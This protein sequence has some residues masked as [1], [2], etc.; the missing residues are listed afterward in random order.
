MIATHAV[1]MTTAADLAKRQRWVEKFF[2]SAATLPLSFVF[3]ETK[4]TG[5]PDAWQPVT[6]RRRIDAN[7]IETSF[8]GTD[9]VTGLQVRVDCWTYQ[10]YPV[11]EWVVWLTNN[12]QTATPIIRDLLALDGA[13]P[14]ATPVLTHCNGDFYS[15]AGYTAAET[16][17]PAGER[18]TFAPKGGRSCD[19]AF[20][21]YRLTFADGGLAL[22]VGW[23]A[24]WAATFQRVDEGVH[25]CAGQEKTHLRLLPGESIRT[26]RMAVLT[27]VG[28]S[29]RAVNLWR[30][31]YLAHLL[32]RPM[33]SRYVP[34]WPVPGP[35][36]ERNSRRPPR[37]I[38]ADILINFERWVSTLM[39]GGS[40]PAGIPVI[41]RSTNGAGGARVPGNLTPNAF[42]TG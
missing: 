11:I 31:W 3:A 41:T 38:N 42:P 14:G 8:T 5:I 35:T 6:Q 28:D 32:P 27:W 2:T 17:L 40:T 30:R 26:P 7:L 9:P 33:A 36:K 39:S 21:Y 22:A 20:P 12:G 15:A 37:K 29:T 1:P 18:F 13:F 24:Q 23:P 19:G 16:P 4:I 10:D 34:C 25:L